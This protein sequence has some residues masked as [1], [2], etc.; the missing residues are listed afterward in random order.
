MIIEES[1]D[2]SG[3]A[4]AILDKSENL[5]FNISGEK[6]DGAT[7]SMKELING[8]IETIDSLYQRKELVTGIPAGFADLGPTLAKSAAGQV[9]DPSLNQVANPCLHDRSCRAVVEEAGTIGEEE[10]L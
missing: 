5:I 2:P 10:S 8:T 4:T 9:Q 7:V 3:D 1:F 6:V